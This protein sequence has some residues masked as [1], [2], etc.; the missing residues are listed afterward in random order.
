MYSFDHRD[1][2]LTR[3]IIAR[4]GAT[5]RIN[6]DRPVALKWLINGRAAQY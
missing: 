1:V 2:H 4:H 5:P 6:R 3:R